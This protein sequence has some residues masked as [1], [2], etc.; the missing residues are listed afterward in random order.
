MEIERMREENVKVVE[1]YLN[2][3]KQKDLSL[4]PF[5]DDIRFEDPVAGRITGAEDLR[6]FLLN[7]VSAISD[8]RIQRHVCEGETVA[9]V[10][11]ADTIFGI[12]P[13]F[14]L[15]RVENGK[16]T[17]AVGYFDPRPVIGG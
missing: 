15:F 5:A 11:E 4:A 16:I 10:W 8:V 7:F 17:E 6:A 1:A 3:L 2:A 14:E 9:T 12:I 13:I